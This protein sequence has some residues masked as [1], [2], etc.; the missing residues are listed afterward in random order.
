MHSAIYII[1]YQ[2]L[3]KSETAVGKVKRATEAM[4]PVTVQSVAAKPIADIVWCSTNK[5]LFHANVYTQALF[6]EMGTM[7]PLISVIFRAAGDEDICGRR[8]GA[9]VTCNDVTTRSLL[10]LTN[11]GTAPAAVVTGTSVFSITFA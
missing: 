6:G 4:Q 7:E 10:R 8:A 11:A 1:N 3:Q 5:R 2:V 9:A